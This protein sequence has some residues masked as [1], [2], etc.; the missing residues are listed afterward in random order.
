MVESTTILQYIPSSTRFAPL[1]GERTDLLYWTVW[2]MV[3]GEH[4]VEKEE[5][6]VVVVET[7][8]VAMAQKL[9][10]GCGKHPPI[11]VKRR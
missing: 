10:D 4:D 1:L 6:V 2:R 11:V 8:A 7:K 9:Y 5:V 3:V